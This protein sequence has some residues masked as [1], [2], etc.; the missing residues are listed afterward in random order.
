MHMDRKA[1]PSAP[2]ILYIILDRLTDTLV[3]TPREITSFLIALGRPKPADEFKHT[4]PKIVVGLHLLTL[5]TVLPPCISLTVSG[6]D[7]QR[8]RTKGDARKR[9]RQFQKEH[10]NVSARL[11]RVCRQTKCTELTLDN[12]SLYADEI[13]SFI[14]LHPQIHNLNSFPAS[15]SYLRSIY[16]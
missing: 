13:I 8:G 11:D 10:K 2:Y 5:S 7:K 16:Q 1:T 14:Q 6:G 15:R 9:A 12:S 3:C 4:E